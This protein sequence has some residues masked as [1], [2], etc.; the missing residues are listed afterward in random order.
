MFSRK[1]LTGNNVNLQQNVVTMGKNVTNRR[2]RLLQTVEYAHQ[3]LL[4]PDVLN[5]LLNIGTGST[6]P[7]DVDD[8]GSDQS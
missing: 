2:S 8:H 5:H 4:T 7:S 6:R 1:V 3:L